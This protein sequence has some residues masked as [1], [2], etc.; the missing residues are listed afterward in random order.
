MLIVE[1][2][3]VIAAWSRYKWIALL[4]LALAFGIGYIWG[5]SGGD[6]DG[7]WVIDVVAIVALVIMILAKPNPNKKIK[8]VV[9]PK[10]EG[11]DLTT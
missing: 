9:Q 7:A 6:L 2:L 8:E 3:L 1:I 5:A 11:D 10:K 4:P